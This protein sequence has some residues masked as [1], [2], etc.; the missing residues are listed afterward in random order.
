M[1]P[2]REMIDVTFDFRSDSG[3]GDPDTWSPTLASSHQLLWSKPLPSGTPFDLDLTG[4][5]FQL[6][7]RSNPLGEFRLSSDA[8]IPTWMRFDKKDKRWAQVAPIIESIPEAKREEFRHIGYTIG[9]MMIWP[10]NKI[11][12]VMTIN[13]A[14]GCNK[15]MCDRF[16]LTVESIR[17]YYLGERSQPLGYTFAAYH[18][19]FELFGDFAGFVEFFLLQDLVDEDTQTVK[20]MMPYNSSFATTPLPRDLD[21]YR[22][23]RK[24]ATQFIEA[25]NQRIAAH[26]TATPPA[27]LPA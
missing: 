8:V 2:V 23:Y 11:P 14:R 4:P 17:R 9:G 27:K 24:R 3:R 20:F 13:Q 12:G 25:R 26:I 7:H 6:H 22:A 1:A 21:A 10:C 18:E 16:D 15:S 19:F 5:P